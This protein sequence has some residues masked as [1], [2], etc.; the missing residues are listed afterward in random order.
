M[1]QMLYRTKFNKEYTERLI[2]CL[3]NYSKIFDEKNNIYKDH[4]LHDW[5][6]QAVDAYHF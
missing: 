5:T 3:A 2:N 1:R 4:P 6:F